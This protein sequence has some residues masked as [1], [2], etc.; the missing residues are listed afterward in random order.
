MTTKRVKKMGKEEMKEMFDLV[1]YAFN[2]EPTAERQERFEKLLSHTQSYGF[3]IDEQLTSQ[4]MATPFQVNFHGVRYP[5]AGI[6]YVASYPEY[7]G[8]GGISAIMKE[9][10]ADLA[11]QKVALSYL[12]PFSYPFYRQYGYEQTFEQAEYTIKTEDWPRVKRVPGTIKRVSWADGK[13]VI[14]DVYLEN[15]RAHSGGV[16]RETWWLDYTLNRAS[17][18]NNQAIY[19]SSEGKAEGYVIYRIAAGTFEIV[20]WN[21]LTNTAFKALAG[22]IG[23]HSGSVQSFHWINGFAGKDLN[24]L[25]PT[26]AASVKI[27][28]YMMARIVE[29]QTFLEKNPF[30][31]GEKE[32]YSL[33]IEDS[34]GPWNEGIW[35]ITID[36]QGKATV[37]KG[38]VEKEGTAALKADIQTWTQLFLG[39]RSAETLSFYERLQGDATTV[40]RLGQRLVKGMP[41]LEDYF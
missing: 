1:I 18:P 8:E 39:Y 23:S 20:E 32:T 28:P 38:A 37:T 25:M 19:Y 31:S 15:Q 26:P 16:I 40:Q 21:Y 30:Q 2:Q 35:T 14:K 3:L 24:D 41:I 13:E 9:M 11:K 36:E 27:L 10:L 17:K 6:G 7:R 29:L 4:V 33:E 34:Y 5:M 22:F 12:A